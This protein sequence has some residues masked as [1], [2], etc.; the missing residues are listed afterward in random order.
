MSKGSSE[1]LWN[2]VETQKTRSIVDRGVHGYCVCMRVS[3]QA[4]DTVCRTKESAHEPLL[5]GA[6][7]AAPVHAV[8]MLTDEQSCRRHPGDS[9]A[10]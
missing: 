4:P 2:V 8:D 1:M 3:R 6:C 10:Q 7:A 5:V 9:I